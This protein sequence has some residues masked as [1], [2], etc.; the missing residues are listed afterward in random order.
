MIATGS[1]AMTRGRLRQLL[2][3]IQL[4]GG[5]N[6]L[7]ALLALGLGLPRHRALHVLRQIDVLHFDGRHLDPPGIG[8]LIEDLL[9]LLIEVVPLRQ[10]IIQIDLAQHAA[11]RR[12]RQLRRGVVVVLDFDDG[13]CGDP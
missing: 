12:L 7:G 10:Q 9:Q 13:L 11:Q 1:V 5:V 8:A 6:D 2:R 4:A 3:R